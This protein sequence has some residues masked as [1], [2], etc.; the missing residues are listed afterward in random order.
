M[1]STLCIFCDIIDGRAPASIVYADERVIAFMDTQPVNPG[2]LL[3]VPRTH[4]AGLSYLDPELGAYLFRVGMRMAAALRR[5]TVRC[6]GTN[7]SLADG[8]AA[9]QDIFHVHLHVL[10]RF[11]GDGFGFRFNPAY[12]RRP[13]RTTLDEIAAG[14]RLA[15]AG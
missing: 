15:L 3:I 9:G 12:F 14:I 4:A 7:F 5:S 2:H 8:E 13:D 10:P 11:E 1:S 6:E